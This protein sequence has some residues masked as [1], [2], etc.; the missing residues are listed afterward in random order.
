MSKNIGF[1]IHGVIDENPELFST[2]IND[3]R[4]LGYKIHILTGS[5]IT[6]KLTDQLD[7]Y[8]INY[9]SLFS[10]LEYHKNL[11]SEMWKDK[12]GWWID[13]DLWNETK[14][15]YAKKKKLDFHLDDTRIYGKYF[16]TPF[17]H[18]TPGDQ[19]I[20]EI[21]GDV[22]DE[23]LKI[24]KKHEGYYKLKFLI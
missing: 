21:K 16:E 22:S 3:F 19:R 14:A 10:I 11:G 5:L 2:M 23:I 20:L 6:K 8:K 12:R 9:D 24:L 13:D 17:G 15:N 4:E 18:I 1:D 7:S